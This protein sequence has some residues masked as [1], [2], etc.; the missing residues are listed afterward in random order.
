[1]RANGLWLLLALAAC[2]APPPPEEP[3][4]ASRT[5][6]THALYRQLELVLERHAHLV[7]LKPLASPKPSEL[8]ALALDGPPF[9]HSELPGYLVSLEWCPNHSQSGG[10]RCEET[11]LP[12]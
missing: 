5:E 10:G 4:T 2:Q 7:A 1:M 11:A 12:K 6:V 9:L 3:A 8:L